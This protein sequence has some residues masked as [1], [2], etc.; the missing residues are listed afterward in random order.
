M[1][2]SFL[3]YDVW[4]DYVRLEEEEV[5]FVGDKERV[6]EVYERVVG[7]VL[8]VNEKCY[9]RRYIYLWINYVLFEEIE[10]EDVDCVC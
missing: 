6:R 5:F 9:W 2:K 8:L 10:V 3:N 4:F 7:N 1:R